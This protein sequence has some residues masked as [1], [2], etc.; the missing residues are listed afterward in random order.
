MAN[1]KRK[2]TSRPGRP[3]PPLPP[4]TRSP[5][6]PVL[7]TLVVLD[8]VPDRTAAVVL[9]QIL[10]DV[11]LWGSLAP[12]HR[13]D[14]FNDDGGA[15]LEA[16][17]GLEV[18]L[19]ALNQLLRDPEAGGDEIVGKLCL[20]IA[21]W[22]EERRALKS[23]LAFVEAAAQV[24]P[25]KAEYAYRAGKL[26]R[27]L[28][29]YPRA[30]V[31]L[32]RAVTLAR[33]S[34]DWKSFALSFAGLGNLYRQK[35]NIPL[36]VHFHMRSL[37]VARRHGLRDL[38]GDA[39]HNLCVLSLEA[40]ATREGYAYA[41]TALRVYGRG[42]A[43]L[44]TLAHDLAWYWMTRTGEFRR[45]LQIF[46]ELLKYIWD[47]APRLC[48]VTNIA[49]AAGG[50][51]QQ[52]MFESA[53]TDAWA[54]MQRMPDAE[55]HAS[56][57]LHLAYGAAGLREWAHARSAA[58]LARS[59]AAERQETKIRSDAEAVLSMIENESTADEKIRS[60]FPQTRPD[61]DPEADELAVDLIS[62]LQETT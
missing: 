21:E 3:S 41:R 56:A 52:K 61:P 26:A 60:L 6:D 19:S 15:T 11:T 44:P 50:A 36:A 42:H 12:E 14:L 22:L 33:R 58:E 40:E 20:R 37:R 48:V 5:S 23:A 2:R 13:R 27:R 4:L 62:A 39:L 16:V 32:R 10:Q 30:E 1:D 54:M 18:S 25:R 45:A 9:W 47:P 46:Q 17:P 28:A 57:L 59:L 38:A 29:E 53:W 8:E 51:G 43:H 49:R 55:G 31:W 24:L 34:K 7:E 35:G